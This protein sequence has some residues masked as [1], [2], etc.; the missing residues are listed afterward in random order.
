MRPL[1]NWNLDAR[2]DWWCLLSNPIHFP[3]QHHVVNYS[4]FHYPTLHIIRLQ[5]HC[6]APFVISHHVTVSIETH[7]SPT[8]NPPSATCHRT[9][10]SMSLFLWQC[11]N[12]DHPLA[13][14]LLN[15]NQQLVS[16]FGDD[17]M[18]CH[19]PNRKLSSFEI[20]I[21]PVDSRLHCHNYCEHHLDIEMVLCE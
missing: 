20:A 12:S 6:L 10:H 21:I 4:K 3:E 5:H 13:I 19:S 16:I 17:M 2:P 9:T 15:Y 11:Q 7:D 8:A 1:Y 14:M 18:L